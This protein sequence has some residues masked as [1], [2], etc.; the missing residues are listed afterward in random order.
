MELGVGLSVKF[1][2]VGE[3]LYVVVGEGQLVGVVY[4]LVEDGV[5]QGWVVDYVVLLVDG[6]LVGDDC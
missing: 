4:Q 3:L 5:G 2:V 1:V 6:D